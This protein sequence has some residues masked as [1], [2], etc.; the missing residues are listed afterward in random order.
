MPSCWYFPFNL[1]FCIFIQSKYKLTWNCTV[2]S[3][4]STSLPKIEWKFSE[5]RSF[6]MLTNSPES[7]TPKN[8]SPHTTHIPHYASVW[9]RRH[10]CG[11]GFSGCFSSWKLDFI[12]NNSPPWWKL[13]HKIETRFYIPCKKENSNKKNKKRKTNWLVTHLAQAEKWEQLRWPE[14]RLYKVGSCAG[15]LRGHSTLCACTGTYD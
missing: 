6:I 12:S 2:L 7:P 8:P 1:G 15:F 3:V 14:G 5:P 9:C 10:A 13:L 11:L 4:V